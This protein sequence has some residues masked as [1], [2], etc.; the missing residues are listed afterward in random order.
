MIFDDE[1][2][3]VD[4]PHGTEQRLLWSLTPGLPP[5]KG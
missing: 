2:R 1:C 5:R 4:D 3:L